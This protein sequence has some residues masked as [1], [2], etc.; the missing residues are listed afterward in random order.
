MPSNRNHE[1][2]FRRPAVKQRYG[3]LPDSTMYRWMGQGRFPKPEKLG[4]NTVAWRASVLDEYD[5][6]PEGWAERNQSA[7]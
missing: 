7:A 6:D 2:W 1:T 5:R 3:N 4:P